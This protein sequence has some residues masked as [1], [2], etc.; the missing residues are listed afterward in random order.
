MT[1]IWLLT[2]MK[3][4]KSSWP[5]RIFFLRPQVWSKRKFH[6]GRAQGKFPSPL[7]AMR[8]WLFMSG[9]TLLW[10]FR[11][12]QLPGPEKTNSGKRLSSRVPASLFSLP[13]SVKHVVRNLCY[14]RR[15]HGSGGLVEGR[16]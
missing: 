3:A 12:R 15:A 14:G 16:C 8:I 9:M 10:I 6:S 7:R 11:F 2:P 5:Q 13:L 4:V 1:C